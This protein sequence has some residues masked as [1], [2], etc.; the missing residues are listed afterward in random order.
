MSEQQMVTRADLKRKSISAGTLLSGLALAV[1]LAALWFPRPAPSISATASTLQRVQES[2]ILRVG[3]EGYAPY[4]IESP[5]TSEVSGYSVDLAKYIADEAGWRVE[6]VKTSPETKIVDLQTGRFDVMTEPIFSTIPRAKQVTFTRPYAYFGY[7]AGIVRKGER[8]FQGIDYLNDSTVT[9]AVRQGYTDQAYVERNL[10]RAR[11]LA[12]QVNDISQVFL[13][14]TTGQADIALADLEQVRAYHEA[15]KDVVDTRFVDSPPALVPA[16]FI[17]RRG[18]FEFFTFLNAAIDYMES[19]A[20]LDQLDKKYGVRA[21][22]HLPSRSD[23][24]RSP[25]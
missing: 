8:R 25:L 14:V 1:A 22:R 13:A 20:V 18:D 15:H 6:W 16:G 24:S 7:A 9:I 2:G 19:N 5:T 11:L 17:L 10:P 12:M 21:L 3:Y 4:V 23:R